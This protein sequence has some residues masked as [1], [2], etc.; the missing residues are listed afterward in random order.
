MPF[1]ALRHLSAVGLCLSGPS[2]PPGH[3]ADESTYA[4]LTS[5]TLRSHDS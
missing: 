1:W 2:Q 3:R 4:M 5:G